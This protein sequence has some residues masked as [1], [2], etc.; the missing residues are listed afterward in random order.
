MLAGR[1]RN[2]GRYDY[3][4]TDEFGHGAVVDRVTPNDHQA[5]THHLYGLDHSSLVCTHNGREETLTDHH[6]A[7][8]VSEMLT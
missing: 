8:V 4:E 3:G 6:E 2:S 5:T 7:R 1:Q